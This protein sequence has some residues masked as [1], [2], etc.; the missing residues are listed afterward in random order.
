MDKASLKTATSEN[1]KYADHIMDN[2]VI[3]FVLFIPISGSARSAGCSDWQSNT[4]PSFVVYRGSGE[5]H[6]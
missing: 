5:G 2:Q 1:L 3:M 4:V 6:R